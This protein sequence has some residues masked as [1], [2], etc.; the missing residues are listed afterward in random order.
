M[1]NRVSNAKWEEATY[2]EN[3]S[4]DVEFGCEISTPWIK[5]VGNDAIRAGF[6][7]KLLDCRLLK[8]ALLSVLYQVYSICNFPVVME[9]ACK[10]LD[11][12]SS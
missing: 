4:G 11:K 12:D 5:H 2:S 9:R 10:K 8:N 1:S 7:N 6:S 3:D